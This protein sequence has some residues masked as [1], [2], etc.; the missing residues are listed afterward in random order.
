[1][2]KSVIIFISI[3][4]L[5]SFSLLFAQSEN[6]EQEALYVAKKAYDDGFYEVSLNLFERF[7]KSYPGSNK[8]QEANL[9]IAQCYFQQNKFIAALGLLEKLSS[10]PNAS[11]L[12]DTVYYWIGEIHFRGKDFKK[13]ISF[14]QKIIDKFPDSN[15]LIHARYSKG[16][17]LFESLEYGQAIEVFAKIVDDFPDEALAQDAYFKKLECLYNLNNYAELK[18][19]VTAF[20]KKYPKNEAYVPHLYFLKAE[21][22]F[23]LEDYE[24]AIREYQEAINAGQDAKVLSLSQLGLVWCHLKMKNYSRAEDLLL[25]INTEN[26]TNQGK[27]GLFIAKAN[28]FTQ[29]KDFQKALAAWSELEKIATGTAT[30]VQAFLGRAET[31]YSLERYFEAI[32]I[33][34][35]GLEIEPDLPTGVR[36]KLY[37][38]LAWA[39]LKNGQFREAIVEFQ[40][41]ASFASDKIIKVAALCQVGDAYQD[42][43]D[44]EKAIEAYDQILNNYPNSFYVDYVQYQLGIACLRSS[45]YEEAILAFRTLLLNFPKSKLRTQAI[46]SMAISLFQKQDYRGSQEALEKYTV[47]LRG[48]EFAAEGLYLLAT[49]LYNQGKFSQAMDIF[50]QVIRDTSDVKIIQKAEYEIADCLYQ[51]GN[52]K[53]A[54]RS[55]SLLRAKY[56]DSALSP[57]VTWWL[58]GYYFRKG[59]LKFS[60]RYFTSLINDFSK[61][62]LLADGYYALGIIDQEEGELDSAIDN[63]TRAIQTGS[64]DIKAQSRIAIAD[65]LVEQGKFEDA[66]RIYQEAIRDSP[67]LASLIY[68]KMSRIFEKQGDFAQAIGFYKKALSTASMKEA[69][70]LQFKIAGILE[71]TGQYHQAVEEYLKIPYLY[72]SDSQLTIKAYLSGAQIYENQEDFLKARDIYSKVA[73]MNVEEAKYAKEKIAWIDNQRKEQ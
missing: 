59:D 43:E 7:L 27:E 71:K 73:S 55:F 40:K 34:Q 45:R 24:A 57:E 67:A 33:Y 51:L 5:L 39:Y 38:G 15:F 62:G 4:I 8:A 9:Y 20:E 14:Y 36:D 46:Y 70:G 54:M 64:S 22:D 41:A 10:D 23:Y 66:E 35:Q 2:P 52:E 3:S 44:Y 37:Y 11:Q 65:I 47:D 21:S 29:T 18:K 68:P 58:G 53:E 31:L 63:L 49:S 25:E 32:S 42:A 16:W 50:K 61:S 60:R 6:R 28:L 72:P 69:P 56:P 48:S 30:R 26:L 13:A 17:C 19:E 12:R 1:M